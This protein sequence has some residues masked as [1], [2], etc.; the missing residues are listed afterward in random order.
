MSAEF[1]DTSSIVLLIAPELSSM[2]TDFIG[3]Y[4]NP[5]IFDTTPVAVFDS[6][7]DNMFFTF[8]ISN[9]YF[10]LYYVHVWLLV[11]LLCTTFTLN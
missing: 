11:V 2:F 6:Y 7:T 8:S 10:I 9:S 3:M 1:Y 5:T 4:V